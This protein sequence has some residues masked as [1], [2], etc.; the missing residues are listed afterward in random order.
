M[1][2]TN[3]INTRLEALLEVMDARANISIFIARSDGKEELLR[4]TKIYGLIADND[5]IG[6]Y[7]DY[8]VIGLSIT[9]NFISILIEEEYGYEISLYF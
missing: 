4:S 5:F 7:G 9:L 2:N 3:I 8:K 1:K 6:G